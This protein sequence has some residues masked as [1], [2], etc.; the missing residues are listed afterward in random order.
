[1]QIP[2]DR[3]KRKR[4]EKLKTKTCAFPGCKE[5]FEG[6]GKSKYCLE[7]RQKKYRKIIDEEKIRLKNDLTNSPN[8]ILTHEYI[9]TEKLSLKCALEGCG[10][11]FEIFLLPRVYCYPKYCEAHR[12]AYKRSL[13]LQ[14]KPKL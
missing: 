12:N 4:N 10:H 7:H 2:K 13:Y 3:G 1:M 11:T 9:T 14:N 5:T 8:Q 6:T